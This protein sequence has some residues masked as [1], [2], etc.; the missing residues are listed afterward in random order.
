MNTNSILYK[1]LMSFYIILVI[2]MTLVDLTWIYFATIG[3][4]KLP[5]AVTSSYVTYVTDPHTQ[6]QL[7]FLQANYYANNNGSGYEMVELR[8]NAYSGTDKQAIYSRGFQMVY[9]PMTI[10]GTT[11][12]EIVPLIYPYDSYD[13]VSFVSGHAYEWGDIFVTEIDGEIYGVAFDGTYQK[14]VTNVG[15]QLWYYISGLFTGWDGEPDSY[16]DVETSEYTWADF[17]V[18]IKTMIRSSSN[19][20][21]DGTIALADLASYLSVYEYDEE[22]GQFSGEPLGKNT[23]T[24]AYFT[25]ETH[26]DNRG[27][28]FAEQSMFGSVAGDSQ[29]NI[30]GIDFDVDY[31]QSEVINTLTLD[32]FE[33]RYSEINQ[34]NFI[35]LHN[36]TITN[37]LKTG[38]QQVINIYI[39]LD[40]AGNVIGIDNYAFDGLNIGKIEIYSSTP[41]DFTLLTN[42]LANCNNPEI[43]T[44]RYV[45]LIG[46]IGGEQ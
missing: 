43:V 41:K 12:E 26:F 1:V 9:M 46:L 4:D 20:T 31:W 6:E 30:S 13:G 17:M 27:V 32:D 38:N 18:Y 36:T 16:M 37:F 44:N 14:Y 11:Q 42:T 35:Y 25:C 15:K 21:G 40:Q 28:E 29:F 22:S 19:G 3:K 23:L 5:Q 2:I 45:N 10:P 34:G 7:P 8:I 33:Q 24:N 39:D